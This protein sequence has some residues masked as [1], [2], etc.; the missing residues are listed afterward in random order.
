LT[1]DTS[2]D[3]ALLQ[4]DVATIGV[5]SVR[6]APPRPGEPVVVAGYPLQGVLASGPQVS[7]GIVTALAG[8]QDDMTRLQISAPVQPG[9]S[10][11]PVLD[12]Q[13]LVVGVAVSTIGTLATAVATGTLPQNVNFAIKADR[14]SAFLAFSNTQTKERQ[15]SNQLTTEDIAANALSSVALVECI[16]GR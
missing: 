14:V 5:L 4:A 6:T 11:A 15:V 13:G 1:T 16:A 7:T 2:L 3:L 8:L 12:R 10:G 9:N